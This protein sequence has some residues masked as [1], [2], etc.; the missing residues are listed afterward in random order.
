MFLKRH[1]I[2]MSCES[3]M[4]TKFVVPLDQKVA[5][6][7]Y[8][9]FGTP[10][11]SLSLPKLEL[12]GLAWPYPYARKYTIYYDRT[13]KCSVHW[14]MQYILNITKVF[15]VWEIQWTHYKGYKVI[16]LLPNY[17]IVLMSSKFHL[18]LVI[19]F[20]WVNKAIW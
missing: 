18:T 15:L 9:H 8:D 17:I 12:Y 2:S 19:F 20:I 6:K 3:N 13:P 11:V 7:S 14:E 10:F 4:R 16:V 1:E 5:H